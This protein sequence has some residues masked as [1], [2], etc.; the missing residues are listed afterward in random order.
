[1]SS[2]LRELRGEMSSGLR[3]LRV[4]MNTQFRWTVGLIVVTWITVIVA[5]LFR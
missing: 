3:E 5:V 2:E 4:Q 1:M